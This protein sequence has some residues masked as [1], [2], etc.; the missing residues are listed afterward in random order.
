MQVHCFLGEPIGFYNHFL[1]ILKLKIPE[2]EFKGSIPVNRS[3]KR[4]FPLK[5]HVDHGH[6][7]LICDIGVKDCSK[8]VTF[9]GVV[10]VFKK[11]H[12]SG[13]SLICFCPHKFF[14]AT[15]CQ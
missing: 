2:V 14:L 15:G 4:Y 6:Y 12:H 5:A 1:I 13:D 3:A 7:G 9:R 11:T 8:V 10:Q